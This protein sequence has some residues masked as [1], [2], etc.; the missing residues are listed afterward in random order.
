[1]DWTTDG[2][3]LAANEF[4]YDYEAGVY[5]GGFA[6]N[7]DSFIDTIDW[8]PDNI[9]LSTGDSVGRIKIEDASLFDNF[10]SETSE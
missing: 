6:Y 8:H 2:R 7:Q 1:M 3:Y 4:I 9:R 10:V 5:V